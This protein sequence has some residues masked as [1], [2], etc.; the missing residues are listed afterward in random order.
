MRATSKKTCDT[1]VTRVV[2]SYDVMANPYITLALLI[3]A[4]IK[5][6]TK[7]VTSYIAKPLPIG[8]LT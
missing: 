8:G 3:V 5:P 6:L 7:A 4:W 1:S 2:S